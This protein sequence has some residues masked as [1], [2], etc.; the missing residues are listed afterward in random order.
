MAERA[1]AATLSKLCEIEDFA[2]GP[3]R[4]A[5]RA[6]FAHELDRF[7][8]DFPTGVE[9]RKHWEVAMT[10]RT[11]AETG[12]L[13]RG[14]TVLGVGAGNEPTA[15]WLTN[16]VGQV[17]ATD[18][19]LSD[20][21]WEMSANRHM[22]TDPGRYWPAPWDPRRLV[23]QHMDARELRYPDETF[24]AV[25]SASSIEHF[26]DLDDV[27]QSLREVHRVLKPGGVASV[28]T[29][30]RVE[31]PPPGLPNVLMFDREQLDWLVTSAQ[32]ELV[33]PLALT[34]S[35]RTRRETQEFLE[36]AADVTAHVEANDGEILFHRLSWTRYPQLVL[37][38]DERTWTSVHLALRR[39][40]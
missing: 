31:G 9:Y 21:D 12:A 1:G 25:F 29:E 24:D 15:F 33:E 7:G 8:P 18:L 40:A 11:L 19:Y 22:L 20:D 2:A 37:R 3:T 13:H 30:Y 39:A 34:L 23:A 26:G 6:V 38:Q 10:A 17:F 4:E 32:L 28:S 5:I 14:A 27:V 35:E 16:S 36:S